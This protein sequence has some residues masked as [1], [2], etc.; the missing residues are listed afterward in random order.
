MLLTGTEI[1][2]P[3]GK[4]GGNTTIVDLK[5]IGKA[6]SRIQ[7]VRIANTGN[8]AELLSCFTLAWKDLHQHV[9]LLIKEKNDAVRHADR[10]RARIIL[11]EAPNVLKLKGLLSARSPA[12]SEDLRE[13]VLAQSDEYQETLERIDYITAVIELLKGKLNAFDMAFTSVKKILSGDTQGNFLNKISP[14]IK[15]GFTGFGVP[16]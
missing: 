15:N 9:V 7:D 8:A 14:E 16:K 6:E 11:D 12:G 4:P 1:V 13:A 3:A 5:E 2:C 10:V